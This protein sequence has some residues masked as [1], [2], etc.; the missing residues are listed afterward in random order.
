MP[1]LNR[2]DADATMIHKRYSGWDQKLKLTFYP[3]RV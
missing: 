2:Q 1:I 3:L